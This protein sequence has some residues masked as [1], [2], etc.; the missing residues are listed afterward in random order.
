MEE[1]YSI[2]HQVRNLD[3]NLYQRLRTSRLLEF[4]Q[5]ASIAHTEMLGAGREKTLDKGLLW[6]VCMQKIEISDMPVYDDIIT[7]ES[8]PGRTMH[9]LFPRYYRILDEQKN[10]KIQGSALWT[11]VDQN[12]RKMA[13]P[14]NYDIHIPGVITGNETDLP[15]PLKKEEGTR[16][17]SFTVPFSYCDLNGHMNNSRYCDL[18]EDVTDHI[19]N[20][21]ILTSLSSEYISEAR[22]G[23]IL[24]LS[25]KE[26][27]SSCYMSA[28]TEKD[29]FRM[30][31]TYTSIP[32]K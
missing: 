1:I 14:E 7:I 2:T 23:D 27:D 4:L 10:V 15:K 29:I 20:G 24:S 16:S 25:W 8:W 30:Q 5:E 12:T 11:L 22:T 28:K 18:T 31:Y 32:S 21:S 19:R 3:V 6:M 9:V 17:S 13:F 26:D